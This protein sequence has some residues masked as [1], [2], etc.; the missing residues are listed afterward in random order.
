MKP[1]VSVVVAVRNGEQFIERTLTSIALQTYSH[2]EI[3]VVD[4]HSTD[5]TREIASRFTD[6]I[7]I[8]GPER[9][10]QRNYGI[11]D[12]AHGEYALYIDAD[13]ILT[14]DLLQS[15][16]WCM[17]ANAYVGLHIPEIIL[18][19]GYWGAVRRFERTFYTGSLIDGARFFKRSVFKSIG[20][21]DEK[22]TGPE[23]WDLDK[24]LSQVGKIGLLRINSKI[25]EANSSWPITS[26]VKRFGANP[27]FEAPVLYHDET[28]FNIKDYGK[29]KNYYASGLLK[30]R[31]K[32]GAGD[33]A[34][35]KQLGPYYRLFGVFI[36][37]GKWRRLFFHPLLMIGL[38]ILR[39]LVGYNYFL[40]RIKRKVR[41]VG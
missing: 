34:I 33:P 9:S 39:F 30:Y 15:C 23:D 26:Y 11:I 41:F 5:R 35:K 8:R 12:V 1:I 38:F 18:A 13:M 37:H 4:N 28:G 7:F 19:Q 40:E 32:W 36:E 6:N 3:I 22:L 27:C 24:R 10:A 14:Q 21:F 16:I 2:T 17:E 25:D 29:K 31:L 20:G